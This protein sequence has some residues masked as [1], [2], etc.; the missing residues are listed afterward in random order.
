MTSHV[1]GHRKLLTGEQHEDHIIRR[2]TNQRWHQIRDNDHA[3]A[4]N[5]PEQII[6]M[7]HFDEEEVKPGRYGTF[8][9]LME[10]GPDEHF[11]AKLAK[12]MPEPKAKRKAALT[13]NHDII[14]VNI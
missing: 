7:P 9:D 3:I 2:E 14:M 4:M 5:M 12:L 6:E 11:V 10:N 8:L 1:P 13:E